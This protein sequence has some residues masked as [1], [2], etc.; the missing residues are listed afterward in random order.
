M[1]LPHC[2]PNF[3][4]TLASMCFSS[5]QCCWGTLHDE[6]DDNNDEKHDYDDDDDD[7]EDEEDNDKD[8]ESEDKK[9]EQ[10][11]ESRDKKWRKAMMT[12]QKVKLAKDYVLQ[13][14]E[15]SLV[16]FVKTKTH[17]KKEKMNMN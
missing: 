9:M 11:L 10:Q 15:G 14:R 5:F 12:S 7:D 16:W 6:G 8:E 3:V 2:L 1:C 4:V 17:W 13:K